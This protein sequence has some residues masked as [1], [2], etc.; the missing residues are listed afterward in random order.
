MAYSRAAGHPDYTSAGTSK[1]IPEIWSP[2]ILKKY[3]MNAIATAICNT[4]H[5]EEVQKGGDKVYIRTVP[6]ITV[7]NH[8]KGMILPKQR[9]ESADV[10]M[11]IDKGK[12][13]NCLL[14]VV[15]GV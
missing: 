4:D 2:K 7:F 8:Q 6:D 12:G 15:D 13:W 11:L 9:P 1:V 3:Y 10:E 5:Q 14:V